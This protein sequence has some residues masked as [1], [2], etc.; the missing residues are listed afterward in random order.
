MLSTQT[1]T[2]QPVFAVPAEAFAM[3]V[4]TYPTMQTTQLTNDIYLER[5]FLYLPKSQISIANTLSHE[6]HHLDCNQKEYTAELSHLLFHSTAHRAAKLLKLPTCSLIVSHE[7]QGLVY[8]CLPISADF[9]A[10]SISC[11]Y[12]FLIKENLLQLR[13]DIHY[14]NHPLF[15]Y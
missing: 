9:R 8:Q 5:H 14:I 4:P 10:K 2:S 6:I 7:E 11:G 12:E 3:L 13:I 15:V 1:T